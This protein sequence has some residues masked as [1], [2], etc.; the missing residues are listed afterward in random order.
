[1]ARRGRAKYG[2]S[3][4]GANLG[5]EA[6]MWAAADKLRN[7]MDAAEYKHVVLGLIF[8]K[9]IS[10]AFEAHHAR[11]E[12]ET[13][14]P[15]S[16]RYVKEPRARY[17]VLEDRD[18]YTADNV[19]W[20]PEDARWSTRLLRK[21]KQPDI[22]KVI[23]DAMVAIEKDN[24]SLKGVLPKDYAR[25]TLDKQR[26]GELIDLIGT[27]GLGD[28]ESRAKDVLGRVY[29]YFLSQFASA[30]GKKGGQF[31]TP[32][33][34]VRVLVEMLAPYKGRVFD[35][36]CGS[37]GMFVQSEKFVEAHGGRIG[38][39]SIYGQESNTT[40]W[41]L[42]KMNLA[43]RGIEANLGEP[44]SAGSFRRD[45]FPDLKADYVLANPPFNDSD[46]SGEQLRDDVRWK[47]GVPPAGNAN[48]AWVQHFIH[49]LAPSGLAGFVLANGS[50]SANQ[51]GEGEIR[52]NIIEADLV[53]CMVALPGQLFY[54][55]QIPVCL[56]FIARDKHDSRLRG[57]R[58]E[59]LFID[60]RKMGA[61]VDRVHRELT[62]E[63]IARI[64]AA[65]HAWRGDSGA[66]EYEDMPGF[67]KGSTLE[68]I[69]THK[70]ALVPGRYVGFSHP[71]ENAWDREMLERELAQIEERLTQVS[72][73]STSSIR[74]LKELLH[75]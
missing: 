60:A 74:A 37:G 75:G 12:V 26:L 21:A 38:D 31:Y 19:F 18:E 14:D 71:P 4:N 50:M 30:E 28:D 55:T 6:T 67:C 1:M 57:R 40:T 52:K 72:N 8:L 20:V 51:S 70:Y 68:E 56:W 41:R 10:D 34:V 49:H 46:W 7:N 3:P 66:D 63:D 39:I 27:I 5:F 15:N 45:Q 48:F 16:E 64:A 53:D 25:A 42:A 47:Y 24:P 13:A 17:E 29:E 36:C 61:L 2:S 59:T 54:S 9:Y 58:G 33:S 44:D 69:R 11:L 35:P 73:A 43:I 23:D 22:G 62:D 65:Y 32:R